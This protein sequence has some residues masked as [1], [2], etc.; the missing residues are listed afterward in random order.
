MYDFT[1]CPF[2]GNK[3][4]SVYGLSVMQT[5]E[6]VENYMYVKCNRCGA[7]GPKMLAYG[8]PSERRINNCI[9]KWN[10]R[11]YI[12]PSGLEL[13]KGKTRSRDELGAKKFKEV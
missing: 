13:P 3:A 11:H 4:G 7:Q 6:N 10:E 5:I 9:N 2:C 8:N 1:L 12:A